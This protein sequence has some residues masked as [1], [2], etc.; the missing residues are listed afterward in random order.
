MANRVQHLLSGKVIFKH[1]RGFAFFLFWVMVLGGPGVAGDD[2]GSTASVISAE[3]FAFW[4][5]SSRGF[6]DTPSDIF[7]SHRFKIHLRSDLK[8]KDKKMRLLS[9]CFSNI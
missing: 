4:V 9:Y 2:G 3:R 1:N 7:S 6:P 5:Y 8:M